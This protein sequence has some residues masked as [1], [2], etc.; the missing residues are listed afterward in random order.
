[1][2]HE[3]N[4]KEFSR[5]SLWWVNLGKYL[6]P[7]LPTSGG[8]PDPQLPESSLSSHNVNMH[9]QPA[10]ASEEQSGDLRVATCVVASGVERKPST[11]PSSGESMA[12]SAQDVVMHGTTL[13]AEE[14]SSAVSG[15][16]S[17]PD[18]TMDTARRTRA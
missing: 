12:V 15:L 16:S 5:A 7:P 11:L 13:G 17:T 3:E 2:Y 6:F 1:M 4:H 10:M 18:M 8:S 9:D 14:E